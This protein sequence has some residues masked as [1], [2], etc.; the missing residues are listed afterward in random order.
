VAAALF[1]PVEGPDR[2]D[3]HG[4]NR[5]GPR[6]RHFQSRRVVG[7]Y[8]PQHNVARR[9]RSAVGQQ[10]LTGGAGFMSFR[11]LTVDVRMAG[12]TIAVRF[13]GKRLANAAGVRRM[14]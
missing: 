10:V 11:P 1:Q 5:R 4:G 7:H 12:V 6:L 8:A 9:S 2:C 13:R 14:F 3:R